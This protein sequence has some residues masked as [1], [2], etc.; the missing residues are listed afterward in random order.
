[1]TYD[2]DACGACCKTFPIFAD[3]TDAVREPRI[4]AEA[5]PVPAHVATADYAHRLFPLPFHAACCFLDAEDRCTVYETRPDVCRRFEAGGEQ[6]QEAR[7]RVGLG[8]LQPVS[9]NEP[10]DGCL[11]MT[12]IGGR[13]T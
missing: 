10:A 9:A 11:R 8:A 13:E 7:R 1:V 3:A 6:C 2:C 12:T 4:V 5:L